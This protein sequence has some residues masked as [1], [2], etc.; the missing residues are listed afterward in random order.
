MIIHDKI[1]KRNDVIQNGKIN[2]SDC[3]PKGNHT[4]QRVRAKMFGRGVHTLQ[5]ARAKMFGRGVCLSEYT[6]IAKTMA[7]L[8][9]SKN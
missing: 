7:T 2:S 4:L 9:L 3:L 6:Y 8:F 1:I 5:R